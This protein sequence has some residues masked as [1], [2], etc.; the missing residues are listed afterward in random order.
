MNILE[1]KSFLN[2]KKVGRPR[3]L[4]LGREPLNK[5]F[6]FLVPVYPKGL[7]KKGGVAAPDELLGRFSSGQF[8]EF[9]QGPCVKGPRRTDIHTG[10]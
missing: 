4:F 6:P 10:R 8:G 9:L 2:Q 7:N 3:H 1:F 5:R